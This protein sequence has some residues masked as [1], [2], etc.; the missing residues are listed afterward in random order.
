MKAR[1]NYEE[2]LQVLL[3]GLKALNELLELEPILQKLLDLACRLFHCDRCGVYL[4]T[5][6]GRLISPASHGLSQEYLEAVQGHMP[7]PPDVTEKPEP[8]FIE[9]AQSAPELRDLRSVIKR[10]GVRSI[11]FVPLYYE[12]LLG[13]LALYHDREH[14]WAP[15]DLKL[16]QAL[17]DQ[18][19]LAVTHARE[20]TRLRRRNQALRRLQELSAAWLQPRLDRAT[21]LKEAL[22]AAAQLVDADAGGLF[23]YHGQTDELVLE[24][25]FNVPKGVQGWR[26]SASE[27]LAGW[28]FRQGRPLFINDYP[29][30][31]GRSEK[32]TQLGLQA[33]L[34]VP[35]QS[36]NRQVGV[37]SVG[38]FRARPEGFTEE[39][40]VLLQMLADQLVVALEQHQL[41]E[42]QRK[43]VEIGTSLLM[44]TAALPEV[45]QRI[46]QA[47]IAQ[48]PFRVGG[49]VVFK[50]P[51][52]LDDPEPPE[53]EELYLEGLAPEQACTLRQLAQRGKLISNRQIVERGRRLGSAYFVTPRELPELTQ[54]GVP[55]P[56][57]QPQPE[58]REREERPRWG[59]HDTLV[60]F[61]GIEGRVLGRIT[62]ADP[63]HGQIPTAEELEYLETFVQLAAWAIQR[64]RYQQRLQALYRVSRKLAQIPTLDELYSQVLVLVREI[65]HYEYAALLLADQEGQSLTIT[66]QAGEIACPYRVGDAI[67]L[68]QGVTGWVAKHRQPARVD[69]V[70]QDPRYICGEKPMGSELAVPIEL[71]EKLIGVLNLES[72][73]RQAFTHE[74]QELLQA[75]ADQLAVAIG[76]L[77]RREALRR[78]QERLRGIYRLSE[79]LTQIQT[80]DELLEESVHVIRENFNYEHVVIFLREGDELVVRGYDTTLPREEVR[81][82][83]FMRLPIE[84]G[85]C[86]WVARTGQPALV[87]DVLKDPRYVE[88]HPAIRSEL[89]V[90]IVEGGQVL[91]VV[92]I[93][94]VRLD[95]FTYEDQELLEALARQLGVALSELRHR[96]QLQKANEFLR[97]LNETRDFEQL[98][99][100][101]LRRAIEMLKP[102]A[103]AGSVV[104]YNEERKTYSFWIAI[105][106]DIKRL[107]Q[108]EYRE[109]EVLSVLR[110]DQPVILT[111]SIQLKNP[112]TKRISEQLRMSPPGSTIVLPIR[113]P[114]TGCVIAFF[115]VNNL[116]EEGVF[117][118]EDA[119][120]LWS[121]RE[122][123]T[124]AV[125]RVRDRERLRRMALHD[126]LTG[127]Y[128]RHYL[129]EFL[130]IEQERAKR[131]GKPISLVMADVDRF[132]EIN[133]RFGHPTGDRVLK[134]IAQLLM[135]N[136]RSGDVVVRY[137]G[138]EFLIVMPETTR[139]EA[140]RVME[141]LRQT[142]E[143]W[144][145]GLPGLRLSVSFGV[146]SWTPSG[147]ET[148][149]QVLEQADAFM[150]HRR[151]G[152]AE[153]RRKRKRAIIFSRPPS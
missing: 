14:H 138:D 136:V 110:R 51:R 45:M 59:E 16:A 22:Q 58:L 49:I 99:Y 63:V 89:A 78:S 32:W 56:S 117:T 46:V 104:L 71:G 50:Q 150:Y 118:E 107:R 47:L 79:R 69:D 24:E 140:E 1:R 133:D 123:I 12:K 116:E 100:R 37:L 135:S 126:A 151:K 137:G 55:V 36:G 128:S 4:L 119:Q 31:A 20:R 80:V 62:L 42:V 97:E 66:A 9:D 92:N 108:V 76:N 95:A 19:A 142:L 152:R 149:E 7:W 23:L 147:E 10:E 18:A 70:S 91:G 34:A 120:K 96:E 64:A 146:A 27:G 29:S 144:D 17:A 44:A 124:A 125:L 93:E 145:P 30:W 153:E 54:V 72:R 121:L 73:R 84:R 68:G 134:E 26:M 6:Q 111:R 61:L 2:R 57:Q 148:L 109:D 3:E 106:R 105:G 122:E 112:V 139:E 13:K 52:P 132:F 85:I 25:I 40:A 102:K 113:D 94:S 131:S 60:Y 82:E 143:G 115:N 43:A 53:V 75:L 81:L 77:Q 87:G 8:V 74:D 127:A 21:L 114:E 48:S 101:I 90:P 35:L 15:E 41:R 5:E 65:F 67:E 129:S 28:V 130:K 103:N 33:A 39:D 86:G 11:L 38:R 83:D 88:G 98:L 141:R